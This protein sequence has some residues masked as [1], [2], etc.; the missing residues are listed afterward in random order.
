MKIA[1]GRI[2]AQ[3]PARAA[4]FLPRRQAKRV[5]EQMAD[6]RRS[7][8]RI[9]SRRERDV[10]RAVE[11]SKRIRLRCPVQIAE[12]PGKPVEVMFGAVVIGDDG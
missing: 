2:D 9:R 12:R 11:R 4:K 3:R 6:A 8:R 10:L 5:A 7:G 1:A